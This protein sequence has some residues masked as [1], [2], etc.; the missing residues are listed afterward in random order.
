MQSLTGAHNY[1][2]MI[3]IIRTAR[4][5]IPAMHHRKTG[6]SVP[7]YVFILKGLNWA[8]MGHFILKMANCVERNL[9]SIS[10]K[11][12]FLFRSWWVIHQS[13]SVKYQTD[14]HNWHHWPVEKVWHFSVLPT[15]DKEVVHNLSK[16]H[17]S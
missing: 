5:I 16:N 1:F 11:I 17:L 7:P 8:C 4:S 13:T 6:I 14:N 15:S 9:S 3:E 2:F 10:F 12:V